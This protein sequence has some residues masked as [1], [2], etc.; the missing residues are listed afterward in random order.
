MTCGWKTENYDYK[1]LINT[2]QQTSVIDRTSV[3]I[4]I[5][6]YKT[7]WFMTDQTETK[8]QICIE[9]KCILLLIH[10]LVSKSVGY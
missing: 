6:I 5:Y 10:L 1:M 4:Y 9:E 2:N 3:Y 7:T 8:V